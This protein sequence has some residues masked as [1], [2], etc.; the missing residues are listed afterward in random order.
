M[1]R[2]ASSEPVI[3]VLPVAHTQSGPRY[4]VLQRRPG[5]ARTLGQ[6]PAPFSLD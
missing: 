4:H 6:S 5:R 3:S 1:R 2:G